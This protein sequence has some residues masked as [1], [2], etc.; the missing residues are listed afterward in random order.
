M[1][2]ILPQ[3]RLKLL[4]KVQR[5]RLL[6]AFGVVASIVGVIAFVSLTPSF[7]A[8]HLGPHAP[9]SA[10][11]VKTAT[12]TLAIAEAQNLT[13]VLQPVVSTTMTPAEA[14][15]IALSQKPAA[16]L[17]DRIE[18]SRTG[19]MG[20]IVLGTTADS[21][22]EVDAYRTRL[23][24]DGHFTQVTVP[25]SVLAGATNGRFAITLTGRF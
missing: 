12:S 8:V 25:V 18:Y 22:S 7:L 10:K 19:G 24:A 21:P 13:T 17:I 4:R 2:N 23:A 1:A 15:R 6:F 9:A 20:T 16:I 5:A 11:S 14:I 3:E